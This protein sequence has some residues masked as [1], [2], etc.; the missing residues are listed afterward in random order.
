MSHDLTRKQ[1]EC[2]LWC[3]GTWQVRSRSNTCPRIIRSVAG[4][5][6]LTEAECALKWMMHHEKLRRDAVITGASIWRRIL[7]IWNEVLQ[8]LDKAWAKTKLVLRNLNF[9]L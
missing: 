5:Y 8:A 7:S 1:V 2:R 9:S 3:H 6:E 4:N